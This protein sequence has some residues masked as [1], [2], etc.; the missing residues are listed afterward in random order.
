MSYAHHVFI[1][2]ASADK[3]RYIQPLVAALS[4]RRLT[5]WLDSSEIAWGD[6]VTGRINEGLRSSQYGLLCL[7]DRFIER[8]W[9]EAEMAAVFALQNASG[10]KRV[11]PLILDARDSVLQRYPLIGGLAYR[12]FSQG[13]TTIADEL[14]ALVQP[15]AQSSDEIRVSIESAHSG[16][17]I[18]LSVLRRASIEWLIDKATSNAGLRT[19]ADVGAFDRVRVRW[20]LV[21]VDAEG[22]WRR[23]DYRERERIACLLRAD[24][25][26]RT[27]YDRAQR[28]DEAGVRDGMVFHLYAIP[29]HERHVVYCLR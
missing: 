22:E 3:G 28:L 10:R 13:V 9:P 11:L 16:H 17:L 14:A 20:V 8:P 15:P 18:S 1:S 26:V 25:R 4:S 7:S 24:G 5:Y 6:S 21:D 2:H 29:E 19:E 12:E 27:S 23:M